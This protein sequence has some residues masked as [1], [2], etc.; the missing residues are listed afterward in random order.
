MGPT[1]DYVSLRSVCVLHGEYI[2][3]CHT[4]C[5]L[6]DVVSHPI[7]H[8][9]PKSLSLFPSLS[10]NSC[11]KSSLWARLPILQHC[12]AFKGNR[13]TT[14]PHRNDAYLQRCGTSTSKT[15]FSKIMPLFARPI[16][17]AGAHSSCARAL[18]YLIPLIRYPILSDALS[19][20]S[21]QLSEL[22]PHA[23]KRRRVA[24]SFSRGANVART[25][26]FGFSFSLSYLFG[27]K[28]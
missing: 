18:A 7:P 20:I 11:L 10:C 6:I 2:D 15:V 5:S 9:Q 24:H 14:L 22:Q 25:S 8:L 16:E 13:L 12:P 27:C 21:Y 28:Y 3:T 1:A 26:R 19:S 17:N 23:T 4:G